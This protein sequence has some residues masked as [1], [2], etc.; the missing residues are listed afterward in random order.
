M[1]HRRTGKRTLLF[2]SAPHVLAAASVVSA[3]E[4]AGPLGG[5]FDIVLDDDT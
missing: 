3:F 5:R 4:D 1:A 2:P